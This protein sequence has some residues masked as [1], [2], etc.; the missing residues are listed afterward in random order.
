MKGSKLCARMQCVQGM[1]THA[2]WPGNL[3][4]IMSVRACVR[5]CREC[6]AS[7]ARI[8]LCCAACNAHVV[9]V[10]ASCA[11]RALRVQTTYQ[12]EMR[13]SMLSVSTA[14]TLEARSPRTCIFKLN[15]LA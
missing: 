14:I 11:L 2:S 13:I 12:P 10:Y 15:N 7:C 9:C 8:S 4:Y 1:R 5:A 6:F 3:I